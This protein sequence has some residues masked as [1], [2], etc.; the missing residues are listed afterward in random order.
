VLYCMLY[1]ILSFYSRS[2]GWLNWGKWLRGLGRAQKDAR[3]GRDNKGT[4]L[5]ADR[6]QLAQ[7]V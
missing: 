3:N 1:R 2:R 6:P 4:M 7:A 5:A